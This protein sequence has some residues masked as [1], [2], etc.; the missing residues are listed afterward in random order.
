MPFRSLVTI[1]ACFTREGD[2]AALTS[3]RKRPLDRDVPHLRDTRLI[4]IASE[5]EKT[6]KQYFESGLFGNRRVQVKVLETQDG[7]SAPNWVL[8]RLN[9]AAAEAVSPRAKRS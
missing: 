6:E 3:R 1:G 5:G 9:L 7:R 8:A 4:I 2:M